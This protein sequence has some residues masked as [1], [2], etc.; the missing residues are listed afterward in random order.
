M[1]VNLCRI[2]VAVTFIF[3]GF[4]KAIDPI[5]T[6]YKLQDYLGSI[7]MAGILPNWTLLAVAVFLAAI[8]F[9]IGIFLLFA[10]QRRLISKL[11]V[12][13]MAFMTIVTVWIVV[14]DPVK[15]CGCF[16]DALHLT[17]TETLIKNIVLLVCSLAIMYRPLAMFRFVS[18]S[19]QWIVTNYTIV[20]IL[21]SSGLSL[22]Y[23]PIFDFRPYHIGV[24]IPRGMEI[25]KGAKL[26]QFKTT[27]IMEKNGQ[28]KEFTLDNYPDA[29]WKFIDS[30][31]VQTSEGYIPPI[32]D[33]SITDNKTGLD[34]TNSVLSHKGYT[35]LLIAPHLETADDSNFGDIDRLYEYAQSYDIPFYCLT[36]ST[37]KAIK[38]WVD[39][40]G[41]EYPFCITDEAVLK[42]IIRSNPGLLLLKDGTIINKWS[43]N[44]LPNEAKLS[45]PISQSSLGKMPKDSVPAKILEIVLWFI[46]PLTLLTLADRL[47]AWS[48]WVRLKEQKDKQKL[49]HLFNKKKSKMRKKIVA[50]N[51]KMNLNLQE[52]VALAKEINEAMTAEKPNC[53]VVICT[54]FIHLASVAKELNASLVGLGAEN[55]ADKEKGAYT[56]EVSAEMV[57][58]TGAQY[59][60]LGHSER[61]QYYGETA[62]ILKEKVLLALKNG[63]KVIFCCGETLEERESNRQND[64]VKAELEG[65]V[66][67]LS[68]EEWKNIILAY[69]PIWA[70]GTG[71]TATS[72]QAEEML[73]YI[74][75][76]V[77]EKYGKEVAEE[78]SILYGGSCKASNAPELFS[79]PNIDGGLIG[80]ASL[81][82]AD[83]KGIIDAWKK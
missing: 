75:S 47:W 26:P 23:L 46:L 28:R 58:S 73:C 74:R 10:I 25:P 17:N 63:L 13:F 57:K 48:K 41:A 62:E 9:C 64:V 3:S 83:F 81:K 16:G 27:F 43:H 82:A 61:R 40:T 34:L 59:V 65:S 12:A 45:R 21:M 50:G 51:W 30:K 72:D 53:D 42:T 66:F 15:D 11:T 60:I 76:I 56:G 14:A 35:F 7:G 33:F 32:H 68:A 49:Y 22:Y 77:A 39:L 24:N 29:S 4:V 2:I 70:I 78:T 6:Q 79:K 44:N 5:G 37:T 52:G 36:A 1:I 80:G 8:E 55:C 20:F 67:N 18:K 19:N 69:E 71:K 54:P 31:T 38:R